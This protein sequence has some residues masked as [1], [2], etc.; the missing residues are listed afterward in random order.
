ML[1]TRPRKRSTPK[2]RPPV[3]PSLLDRDDRPLE[4]LDI[5]A[6][7]EETR[8]GRAWSLESLDLQISEARRR[9]AELIRLRHL[10]ERIAPGATSDD[11]LR[12]VGELVR[13]FLKRYGKA[14][15]DQIVR[16]TGLPEPTVHEY[17]I[18]VDDDRVACDALGR[19]FLA[20]AEL[21]VRRE[22]QRRSKLG[23]VITHRLKR[24]DRA[25]SLDELAELTNAPRD[26]LEDYLRE[27]PRYVETRPGF[28]SLKGY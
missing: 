23:I 12:R 28:W 22:A 24:L 9:T 6:S 18:V 5:R 14:R 2:R 25:V 4:T 26:V 15:P 3:A 16:G 20:G 27:S 19:Y 13:G 21:E 1:M 10:V 11:A 8:H 7:D 17:L